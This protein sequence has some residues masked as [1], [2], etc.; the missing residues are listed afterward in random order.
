MGIILNMKSNLQEKEIRKINLQ[1][2]AADEKTEKATPK[3]RSELRKKGNVRQSRELTSALVLLIAFVGLKAFG[4]N[5]YGQLNSYIK[6]IFDVYMEEEDLFSLRQL[7][8][9]AADFV[10]V[11]LKSIAPLVI[12]AALTGIVVSYAQ[13]GLL[14]TMEPVK[15]KFSKLNP[16]NGIKRMFSG[17][18]VVE[19]LKSIIKIVIIGYIGYSYLKNEQ[20]SILNLMGMSTFEIGTY[21]GST[22]VNTAI[23]M[24]MVLVVIGVI[25]YG[26]Q[27][28]SYER[29]I[30]MTKQEVKDE[31]KQVEGNPEIKSKIKQKQKEISMRRMIQ[32]VPE[33]DVVITNPTHYAVALKYDQKVADAPIVIAK[34]QDYLAQKIKEVAKKHNVEIVENK[35][36]ARSLY[37]TVDIGQAI[38]PELYQAVAEVLAFVYSLKKKVH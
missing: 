15:F 27:W 34:G 26:Y 1:L 30:K 14:F 35:P 13:V 25:D 37:D 33:A 12:M 31:Y 23:R 2:F 29:N 20:E 5:L 6:R 8:V 16:A 9:F 21:I 18:S 7:T 4:G 28:W 19:L 10:L 24:C 3:R 17:T 22:A 32:Q 36:L 11:L 38:P